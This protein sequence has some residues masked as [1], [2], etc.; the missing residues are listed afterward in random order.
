MD[1]SE[2]NYGFKKGDNTYQSRKRTKVYLKITPQVL[3]DA[4][5]VLRGAIHKAISRGI[6]DPTDL[7]SIAKYI[8]KGRQHD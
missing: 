3:A 2:Y 5:G 8:L 6:L 1:L 4:R 7:L